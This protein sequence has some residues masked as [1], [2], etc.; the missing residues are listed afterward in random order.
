[1]PYSIASIATEI[2]NLSMQENLV[3]TSVYP[4]HISIQTFGEGHERLCKSE[5]GCGSS[6]QAACICL[7]IMKHS[8]HQMT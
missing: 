3:M 8:E 7:Y 2:G 4:I 5:M 1:M 6:R